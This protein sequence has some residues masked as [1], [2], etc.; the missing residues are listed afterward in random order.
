[1]RAPQSVADLHDP[2]VSSRWLNL[3][4]AL[5]SSHI[6]ALTFPAIAPSARAKNGASHSESSNFRALICVLVGPVSSA[7]WPDANTR[8]GAIASYWSAER[9]QQVFGV[10]HEHGNNGRPSQ[11]MLRIA[12]GHENR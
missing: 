12:L 10:G 8:T 9:S 6:P 1:M 5:K 11:S 4:G 2:V 3:Y 7:L